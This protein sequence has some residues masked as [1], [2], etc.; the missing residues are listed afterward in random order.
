MQTSEIILSAIVLVPVIILMV[1]R[2]NAALVFLSL[3][4]GDVLVQFVAN[5]T[6]QFA[7][8]FASSK[9]VQQVA[10]NGSDVKL[11]LLLL[12]VIL[13][14]VFMIK[15][16]RG[17]KLA[18]NILP[19][20]GVGLLA[21]LLVIPLLP[22]GTA[23]SIVNS[24]LWMQASRAQDLIVGASALVCLLFIWTMRPK[25]HKGE[26]EKHSKHHKS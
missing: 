6:N 12:P 17:A 24:S 15:T 19:A 4:L 22:S 3:C 7:S 20:A 26:D 25:H 1:L 14:A 2:I 10:N 9:A 23:H 5:D 13:T 11:G 18:L 8:L 16:V 21:N